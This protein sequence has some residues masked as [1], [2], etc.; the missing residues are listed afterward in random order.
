M[1]QCFFMLLLMGAMSA[2]AQDVIVKKD[3]STLVC[4]VVEVTNTE[5]TY[6]KW[7]DLQGSNYIINLKDLTAINYENGNKKSFDVSSIASETAPIPAVSTETVTDEE[8]LRIAK[9]QSIPFAGKKIEKLKRVGWIVGGACLGTG[10]VLIATGAFGITSEF[11]KKHRAADYAL[12]STGSILAAGGIATAAGCLLKANKLQKLMQTQYS[13]HSAPLYQ[14]DF[15]LKNG[16]SLSTSMD[17]LG[18]NNLSHSTLGIGLS[19]NF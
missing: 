8:L 12:V 19:Y 9:L 5:V 10:V 6:K 14:Q 17:L 2:W 7:N 11:H 15:H 13:V 3:G 4:R 18:D 1:K 16:A